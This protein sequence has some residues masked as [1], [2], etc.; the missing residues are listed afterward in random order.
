MKL[1][2]KIIIFMAGILFCAVSVLSV[3]A[4]HND[5]MDISKTGSITIYK[6]DMTAAE[7]KGVDFSQFTATGK[8]DAAAE[9]AL[10]DYAIKGVEFSYLRVG[11]VDQMSEGGKVKLIYEIPTALQT[12]LGLAKADA[13]KTSGNKT[14][15]TGQRI[16]D[17]LAKALEDNT[18]AKD[19]LEEYM[20]NGAEM[21]ETNAS[22]VTSKDNL[23][24]GLYLVVET[25]VPEDVVSTTNP[26]FVQLPMTD[27]QGDEW[28][29]DVVCYPKN[30][31]GAATLDKRVRNNPDQDNVTTANQDVLTDFT[32]KRE[33]YTYQDTV[34]ASKGE[35]LDYQLI[36][37]LPHI[38]S[39]GTYLTA[40][41]FDDVL[42]KGITYG[43]DAV[44]AF[45]DKKDAA[46]EANGNNVDESGALAVWKSSDQDSK[47][48]IVYGELEGDS[49]MKVEM[50]KAGL[51][52]I[53]KKYSDKYMVVY[54]TAKVNSDDTFILGD[55]GNSNEV[56]LT[57]KR[58]SADYYDILKDQCI[59]YS[60]GYNLI[61]KFSDDAGDAAKVQFV[62]QNKT[63]N[64]YLVA[65]ADRPGVYQ[66]TGKSAAKEGA[67]QFHPGTGGKLIVKGIEADQYGVTETHSDA[68][69]S[70][71]KKEIIVN[72]TS[73]R[74]DIT[75]T[76]ANITGTQS[77]SDTDSTANDGIVNGE[78]LENYV[79]V[80]SV[81][82][83]ATV[84]ETKAAMSDCGLDGNL[85]DPDGE[86]ARGLISGNAF[87]DIELTNQ[88][89]FLL[90]M[91]GGKGIYVMTVIG[92]LLA[93]AGA[94]IMR[95]K[96]KE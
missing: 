45:Y 72:I 12:V 21:E 43:K 63:D 49:T 89:Q 52:E 39:S 96:A 13:A 68:G 73:T 58:T 35:T 3:Q 7:K 53:N 36:S 86:S 10:A 4:A 74:A 14:Y 84:D 44:I 61:K 32:A 26:F 85:F 38:T 83:S 76:K 59:V 22:G 9:K 67:T 57:W 34:T 70:L 94:S 47:F 18:T 64:Y 46:A 69:Y 55:Q 24:M 90:P 28:L 19:K 95:K 41:T 77:K 37:K 88:K 2:G 31:T 42:T 5:I 11:D 27:A 78:E 82:A 75:P 92:V 91:T 80:D 93:A 66:I 8:T 29:Y 87:V 54:Y 30:Q 79:T 62:I 25:K 60:F 50:T 65:K 23:E 33:E 15:F 16:N 71:L 48:T 1:S 17:H 20:K 81:E 56:S 6:Y 51:E 40:Y